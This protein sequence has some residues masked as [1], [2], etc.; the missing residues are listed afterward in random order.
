M[1]SERL[2][3]S[4][5]E[6]KV[7]REQSKLP[8]WC[9]LPGFGFGK[10][11]YL[12][13]PGRLQGL[14][15]PGCPKRRGHGCESEPARLLSDSPKQVAFPHHPHQATSRNIYLPQSTSLF[16][17][18][19]RML[20][21]SWMGI[22]RSPNNRFLPPPIVF[23]SPLPAAL[24]LPS[25]AAGLCQE[26]VCF[27]PWKCSNPF[28]RRG[29]MP[30]PSFRLSKHT[31]RRATWTST[32]C[33]LSSSSKRVS[34]LGPPRSSTSPASHRNAGNSRAVCER[35]GQPPGGVVTERKEGLV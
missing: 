23:L 21:S 14:L 15:R 29:R 25:R 27:L 12:S 24:L 32:T 10:T 6:N 26:D 11:V 31:L 4:G 33:H 22:N 28:P 20:R 34:H 5:E 1:V 3:W 2:A 13:P 30:C 17:L 16:S 35:A 9:L 19:Q 7:I 8:S 18:T